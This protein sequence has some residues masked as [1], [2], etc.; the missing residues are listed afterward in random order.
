MLTGQ[1]VLGMG[2]VPPVVAGGGGGAI[3]FDALSSSTVRLTPTAGHV[4]WL[5]TP[6]GTPKGV[7]VAIHTANATSDVTGVTY[8][9]VAMTQVSGSPNSKGSDEV[10]TEH[11]FH[12]GAGIPTGAQTVDIAT[13]A[14]TKSYGGI[15]MTLTADG[16]TEVVDTDVTINS[17]SSANPSC[18]LSLGGINCFAAI[19][20]GS[21][22]AGSTSITPAAGW[23]G[24][25]GPAEMAGGSTTNALYRY[26]TVDD[27][28]V[29]AG[30]TQTADDAVAIAV[31]IKSL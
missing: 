4:T 30:W 21:G 16:N 15:A 2:A 25:A 14:D 28:D 8:G 27:V 22:Q 3:A 11:L 24:E 18:T 26:D 13:S 5:H 9:G 17:D 29:T 12:L 6:V 23:T 20:V 31:A 7:L 1:A 10:M 19:A